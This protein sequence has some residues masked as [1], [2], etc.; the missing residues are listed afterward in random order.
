VFLAEGATA[1]FVAVTLGVVDNER[2]EIVAPPIAGQVV[3]LGHHLLADGGAI[4]VV[5]GGAP[6]GAG[7]AP[8]GAGGAGPP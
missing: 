5:N 8:H 1:R 7:G 3:T 4:R 2:A 6:D